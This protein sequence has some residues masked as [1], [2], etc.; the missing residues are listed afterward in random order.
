MSAVSVTRRSTATPR[1]ARRNRALHALDTMPRGDCVVLALL[2]IEKLSLVETAQ[3]LDLPVTTVR[4]RYDLAL[5][6]VRRSLAPL[7]ARP[8]AERRASRELVSLRRVS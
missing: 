2:L 3:A 1:S 4:R 8:G 6:R 7:L 5:S